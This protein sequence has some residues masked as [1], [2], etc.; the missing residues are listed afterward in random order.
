MSRAP[1]WRHMNSSAA[2]GS[3]KARNRASAPF[4]ATWALR[5]PIVRSRQL[6]GLQIE[7]LQGVADHEL[8]ASH[9]VELLVRRRPKDRACQ[10]DHDVGH[11]DGNS[12]RH[13]GRRRRPAADR[14]E[15]RGADHR[16]PEHAGQDAE[17]W[18]ERQTLD[19]LMFCEDKG[20]SVLIDLT[21]AR[22]ERESAVA[23]ASR[24]PGTLVFRRR[25]RI[26]SGS[27]SF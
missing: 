17:A 9:T 7:P 27:F 19:V 3:E 10:N 15:D 18:A 22:C 16:R 26:P 1:R 5:D 11:D 24:Q 12:D 21:A 8:G 25:T 20:W 4:P 14:H 6:S 23:E 13:E 2:G